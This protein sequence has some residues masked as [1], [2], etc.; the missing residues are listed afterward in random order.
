MLLWAYIITIFLAGENNDSI[1]AQD[2]LAEKMVINDIVVDVTCF[3]NQ[4]R[5]GVSPFTIGVGHKDAPLEAQLNLSLA[6]SK[7]DEQEKKRYYF[8]LI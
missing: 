8:Y 5:F 2:Y 3:R 1:I 6:L 7:V 4:S